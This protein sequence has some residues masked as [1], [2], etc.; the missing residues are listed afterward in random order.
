MVRKIFALAVLAV[1]GNAADA[2]VPFK[3]TREQIE[4]NAY[5]IVVTPGQ[6]VTLDFRFSKT[7]LWENSF[8]VYDANFRDIGHR[9]NYRGSSAPMTLR[10]NGKARVFFLL[11]M[12][13]ESAP[14]AS[15]PWLLTKTRV[16][17]HSGKDTLVR[18]EDGGDRDFRDATVRIRRN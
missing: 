10:A 3:H 15:M 1:S 6:P 11:A 18:Y 5:R 14:R 4:R 9:G 16:V 17:T 7:A 2:A 8:I 13:K 12:H